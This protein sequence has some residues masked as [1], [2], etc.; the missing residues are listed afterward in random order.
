MGRIDYNI[1]DN[2]KIFGEAH[3]SRILNQASNYFHDA[4]TGTNTD[5]IMFGSMLEEVHTFTQTLFLDTRA[6]LTRYD[7]GNLISSNGISPTSL[8]LPGYIATNSTALAI[9]YITFSDVT[10]S[11][12]AYSNK[13]GSFENFDTLQL[14]S[15]ATKIFKSHTILAG[16]DLRA[17]K[18]SWL[19][20]TYPN[21]T[22]SFGHG[23]ANPVT[24]GSSATPSAFG[25]SYA[26][27]ML[28]IP[29]GGS[30]T[31]NPPYQYNSFLNAF[32]VQD[33]WK[34]RPNVT[35]SVGVRLEHEIP[36]NESQNRMVIGF[37][38][39]A[40]NEVTT[41]AEASYAAHPSSLLPAASFLPT[42][43]A[44]FASS[45]KRNALNMAPLYV[46]PRLGITWAPSALKQKGVLRAGYGIYVNPFNEYNQGQNYGFSGST[47]YVQS[48]DGGMHNGS[49]S[50]PFPTATNPIQLPT[51]N[52]LG[53]NQNL[54][55]GMV[56]YPSSLKVAYSE[57]ASLDF[58]YQ[59]G[60]TILIDLGYVNNH[61]VHMSYSN[62]VSAI[63]LLPYLSRSQ[64][65]DYGVTNKLTG[66]TPKVPTTPSTSIVN[67][68]LGLPGIT[69]SYAT[70][71]LMAPNAFLQTYPE[72]SSVTEQLVPGASA[73]YNALNARVAK[74]MGHGLTLNGVFE[75]SRLLGTFNQLNQ[76]DALNY[77]ETTS[78]YP[79]HLAAYG[80]Y[81]LPFGHGR[82][83]FSKNRILDPIIGGWQISAVYQFSSGQPI[84]WNN[85]IYT[86]S[87]FKDLNNVQHS[88]ANRNGTPV[89]NTAVFDTRVCTSSATACNDD[90][91]NVTVAKPYNP[92]IQPNSYNYRTFPQY[93]MR[94]DYT[95]NWD[96]NVQK[97]FTTYKGIKVELRMDAFNLLNRPEY[98]SP[99]VS[100]VSA[101]FGKTSGV[102]SG[103]TARQLQV[104]GHIIF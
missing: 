38:P 10:S 28:G 79:F 37:D 101:N 102:A 32:F 56:F 44:I 99:T 63:P 25:D 14:F 96:G 97:D 39:N 62:N 68:F 73:K 31:I 81:Q 9:P 54:G 103:T 41:Q 87:G 70:A 51:G 18:E 11:P 86:G 67:P 82:E 1:S 94:Q 45:D 24:A 71:T 74:R 76:G 72:F 29:T 13:L 34:A 85:A 30:E 49:I 3:R 6:S 21:G 48:S 89:F 93:L 43:G 92:T 55:A 77:G 80:T 33:D 50:D 69:G 15:T 5:T 104:G 22:F 95:S 2:G 52:S 46:S 78:D 40:T 36:L 65:Y 75:W 23:K 64:Y 7:N 61:Q 88:R 17:K 84:Q 47:T 27:F 98:N 91:T 16:F 35:V 42:G 58:Q 53:V 57:R 66:T 59:I 100:P 60:N 4:L 26:L 20:P 83:F 90:P 19:N 8:G 12:L